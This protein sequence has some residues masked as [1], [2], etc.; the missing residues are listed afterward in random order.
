MKRER[1][2]K[3]L[4]VRGLA[5]SRARAQALVMAGLVLVGEQRVE[6]SSESF[7]PD[8][9]IRVRGSDDPAARYVGRGGL[10]MEAAL[11]A[12]DLDPRDLVCLDV[13]ASTGGFT[14]CLL[15]HGARRIVAVD[16]GHNQLDWR[17]RNDPRVEVREG[18]NARYLRPEDFETR[19]DLVVMDVSFISAT[20]VL[21]ALVPL[22][23]ERGRL[24]LLIKPQFE[25]GRGEV[26]KGGIVSDASQHARVIEEVNRAA[27]DLGLARRGLI[28][29]PIKGADGNREFLACYERA[30][31]A[32]DD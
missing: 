26:G 23:N 31:A 13:G 25:V 14:D 29:S 20:K 21:P 15:Q 1:I 2:D 11:A 30:R 32:D 16:V 17:I 19:F 7:A 27:L 10:K 6:K 12:F 18:V 4:V 22:L 5:P 28:D 24:V 9:L 8:A 3:L